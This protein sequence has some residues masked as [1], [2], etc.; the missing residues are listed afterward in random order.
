MS[1]IYIYIYYI[2]I[3]YSQYFC[4][5]IYLGVSKRNALEKCHRLYCVI[6]LLMVQKSG[7]KTT[8]DVKKLVNNGT[9]TTNLNWWSLTDFWT[10]NSTINASYMLVIT[11]VLSWGNAWPQDFN[12][13]SPLFPACVYIGFRAWMPSMTKILWWCQWHCWV[14]GM[15][16][17]RF[18]NCLNW[19]RYPETWIARTKN[20]VPK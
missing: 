6:L 7:E 16:N 9:K 20:K 2:N 19:Q 10:I 18:A 13:P 1:H 17:W 15:P 8:R 14:C 12:V 3:L 11:A 4:L 5:C